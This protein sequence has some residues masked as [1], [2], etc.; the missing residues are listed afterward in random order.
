MWITPRSAQRGFIKGDVQMKGP[1][2][3]QVSVVVLRGEIACRG[4]MELLML[5]FA[6]LEQ[7]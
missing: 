5:F 1:K 7:L 2:A 4:L 3:S 6:E